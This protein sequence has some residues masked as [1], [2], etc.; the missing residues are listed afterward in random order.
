MSPEILTDADQITPRWLTAT[1]QKHGILERGEVTSVGHSGSQRTFASRVWHLQV[2]YSD[3][4]PPDAPHKLFL[5]ASHP[6]LVPGDFNPDGLRKEVQFYRTVA[7]AMDEPP[8]VRCYDAAYSS[9]TRA[10][11]VLL[12]DVSET[13]DG[14]HEPSCLENCERAIDCLAR[15]HAFWWDHPR[16]M[17]DLGGLPTPAERAAEWAEAAKRTGEFMHFLGNRLLPPWRAVY[18][19]VLPALPRLYA[20][21]NLGRNLTLA[22]GDAHLGNFL[23]PRGASAAQTYLIDWQFWHPTIGGT[24]LAFMMATEWEPAIRRRL[25]EALVRRYYAGLLQRGVR[26]YGWDDC[27]YDY[28]LSVILVSI[29]IPVWRWSGFKWE[30]DFVALERSMQAFEELDCA[31]LLSDA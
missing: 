29:F 26:G 30:P 7:P 20:R 4:A 8:T 2:A 15:F 31:D 12:E 24:D 25:E 1:L 23:F 13:H 22:H 10:C 28:R 9:E 18:E 11:H 19:R 17:S 27:W 5:K 14:C 21:H 16:L 3:D 6:A